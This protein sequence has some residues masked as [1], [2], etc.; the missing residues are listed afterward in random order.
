ASKPSRIE[1]N[2]ELLKSYRPNGVA[3]CG[4]RPIENRGETGDEGLTQ[5]S[6]VEVA[7]EY[8]DRQHGPIMRVLRNAAVAAVKYSS[9]SGATEPSQH[10]PVRPESIKCHYS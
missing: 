3:V 9:N 5:F 6:L 4:A 8:E 2:L 1:L 7:A 10:S